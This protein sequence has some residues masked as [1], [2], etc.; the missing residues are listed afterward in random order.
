[1]RFNVIDLLTGKE[2]DISEIA[3]SEEWAD[4]LLY[5]DMEGFSIGEEG[6]L[7]LCDECGVYVECP[8]D[9]FQVEIEIMELKQ[10]YVYVY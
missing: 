3:C 4:E 2:P 6:T 1:M 8:H 9:R 10:S 5:C 7:Y